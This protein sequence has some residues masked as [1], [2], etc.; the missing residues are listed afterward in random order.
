MIKV[1]RKNFKE[2]MVDEHVIGNLLDSSRI[3]AF[4]RS[5]EWVVAGRDAIRRQNIFYDGEERRRIIYGKDFSM[6]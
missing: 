1:I 2:E 4:H 5:N 3:I 6:K